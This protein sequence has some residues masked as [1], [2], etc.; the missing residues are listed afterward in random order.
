MTNLGPHN[1][2]PCFFIPTS[3]GSVGA[4]ADRIYD[5]GVMPKDITYL[6]LDRI[7]HL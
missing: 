2:D 5:L 4:K 6:L 1:C 7:K 3:I